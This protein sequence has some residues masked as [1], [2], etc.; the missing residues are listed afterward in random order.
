MD[1][2]ILVSKNGSP[3]TAMITV[4]SLSDSY[5]LTDFETDAKYCFAVRAELEG[6][7][8]SGSNESCIET[9]MQR[10]P[11]W[12]NA[13]YATVNSGNEILLS[14]KIDPSSEIKIF[15]LE[16]KTGPQGTFQEIYRSS[17]VSG[18]MLFND[19]NADI[20]KI[21]YYRL[22]ALNNCNTAVTWSNI[23]S[24]IVLSLERNND[25]IKLIWN[26]YK[27][28]L[29]SVGSY[30]LFANTGGRLFREVSFNTF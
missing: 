9:K 26:P 28:W 3:L 23:A 25:D 11:Q 15:K 20:S 10:P 13:D 22:S 18:S 4:D 21:N 24:N 5:V 1:Y 30:R 8:T 17:S 6:G 14:F 16:K 7:S 2:Q 27:E 19:S 29:G 12:I